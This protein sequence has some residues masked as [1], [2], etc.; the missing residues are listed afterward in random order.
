MKFAP[1]TIE[2]RAASG[3]THRLDFDVSDIPAGIATNT[4]YT[5]NTAPLPI[6]RAGMVVKRIH[7][8]LSIPFKDTADAANNST[9]INLGDAGS[10]TRWMSGVQ[11]N[12]NG[13]EVITTF[14]GAAENTIYTSNSQIAFVLGSMA[15][16]SLSSL[17]VGKFY[18][19]FNVEAGADP[20]KTKNP[21]FQGGGYL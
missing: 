1:L 19:L 8:Y 18:C 12:E 3:M 11:L 16:K 5:F 21:P 17:N 10:A 2:E 15:A 13:T 4:A 14:P 6:L 20:A 7:F 9:T